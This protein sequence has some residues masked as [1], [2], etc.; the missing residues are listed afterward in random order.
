MNSEE[1]II[2]KF[3]ACTGAQK[4]IIYGWLNEEIQSLDIEGFDLQRFMKLVVDNEMKGFS[5]LLFG[6]MKFQSEQSAFVV[7]DSA[8]WI[9]LQKK[10]LR[11][12]EIKAELV[13]FF[14][15]LFTKGKLST[16]HFKMSKD[17]AFITDRE[18]IEIITDRLKEEF[19]KREYNITPLTIPEVEKIYN[20]K[21]DE[22][23]FDGWKKDLEYY[24]NNGNLVSVDDFEEGKKYYSPEYDQ[25]HDKS[26]ALQ[27]IFFG[28]AQAHPFKRQID[29]QLINMLKPELIEKKEAGRDEMNS[30]ITRIAFALA[31]LDRIEAYLTNPGLTD[32]DSIKVKNSTGRFIY[33]L[34]VMF[35]MIPHKPE[36]FN[37]DYKP[38]NYAKGLLNNKINSRKFDFQMYLRKQRFSALKTKLSSI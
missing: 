13:N 20:G 37:K 28:Y 15:K 7:K 14:E 23:W 38:H 18:L 21:E 10:Q 5:K 24:D 1:I 25:Y 36:K 34:L 8:V 6:Y 32:I 27:E 19:I 17:S 11:Q 2:E 26:H 35:G 31:D 9:K 22:D 12:R 4:H 29:L 3:H 16:I 30:R 33:D